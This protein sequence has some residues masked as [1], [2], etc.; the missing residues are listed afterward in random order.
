MNV[1]KLSCCGFVSAVALAVIIGT[2]AIAGTPKD[3]KS[4]APDEIKL[5]AGWTESDMKACMVAGTPGK[6]HEQLAKD[7]GVWHGKA[8][9]RMNPGADPRVT[10]CTYTVTSLID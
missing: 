8:P 7:L 5:P 3:S 2:I 10:Q 6:S 4:A 9:M 1:R